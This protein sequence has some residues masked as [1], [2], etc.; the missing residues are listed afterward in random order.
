MAEGRDVPIAPQR[1]MRGCT[2]D[3]VEQEEYDHGS[4]QWDRATDRDDGR[5]GIALGS[6]RGAKANERLLERMF[7][8]IIRVVTA[9]PEF[10][11]WHRWMTNPMK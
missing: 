2:G 5:D 9:F 6:D 10:S 8:T 7:F 11:V 1:V 4:A 3:E